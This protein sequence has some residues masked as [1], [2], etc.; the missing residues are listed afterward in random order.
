MALF[1]YFSGEQ[2]WEGEL[3][4]LPSVGRGLFGEGF[5]AVGS[6]LARPPSA[7]AG[8]AGGRAAGKQQPEEQKDRRGN[9]ALRA[10]RG[11]A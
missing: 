6:P 9:P 5:G 4:G 7:S 2:L 8:R 10:R 1:V 3:I 11:G